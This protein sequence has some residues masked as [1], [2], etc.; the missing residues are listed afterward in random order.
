MIEMKIK[1]ENEKLVKVGV[2]L[3]ARLKKAIEE[4][5]IS[6]RRSINDQVIVLL[7]QSLPKQGVHK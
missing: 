3:P 6:E 1:Q 7:E 4:K 5:A 2:R